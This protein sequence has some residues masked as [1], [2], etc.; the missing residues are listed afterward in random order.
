MKN[1]VGSVIFGLCLKAKLI[2]VLFS[3]LKR[4]SALGIEAFLSLDSIYNN[5]LFEAH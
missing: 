4:F 3:S 1:L 5:R 2:K